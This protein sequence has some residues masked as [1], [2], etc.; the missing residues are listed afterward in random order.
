MIT[1]A[2]VMI[3]SLSSWFDPRR[4]LAARLAW[5]VIVP[6]M[7]LAPLIGYIL[8]GAALRDVVAS[9]GQLQV[10]YANQLAD[11]L[12][13]NIASHQ[14]HVCLLAAAISAQDLSVASARDLVN[15]A[16]VSFPEFAWIG[17]AD[18]DGIV[19]VATDGLLEGTDVSTRPWYALGRE[20]SRVHDVHD[21]VSLAKLLPPTPNGLP[22]RYMDI[23]AP[24]S[25]APG[26]VLGASLNW[27]WVSQLEQRALAPLRA[28]YRVDAL[29]VDANRRVLLGP[30]A[31]VGSQ[32]A[33]AYL[34]A[35]ATDPRYSIMRWPDGFEYLTGIATADGDGDFRGLGWT[36]LVR[37]PTSEAFAS[38]YQLREQTTLLG[39]LSGLIFSA[40]SV[41]TLRRLTSPLVQ[42]ATA[43]DRIENLQPDE[44]PLFHRQDEIGTLSRSLNTL[45]ASLERRVAE[46]TREVER[47]SR[48]NM[49]SAVTLERL[50]MSRDLHDTLAHTL[51]GLLVQ[52]RLVRK[53]ARE[54]IPE[55]AAELETAETSAREALLEARQAIVNLRENPVCDLGLPEAMRKSLEAFGQRTGIKA[56]LKTPP[57]GLP[58]LVDSRAETV[59]RIFEEALNNV[60]KHARANLV[61]VAISM[62]EGSARKAV[63]I[64]IADDGVG[65]EVGKPMEGHY[66]LRGI[67][68]QC[69]LI[70]AQSEINSKP[71]NGTS[72]KIMMPEE[73]NA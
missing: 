54:R 60:E 29:I 6:S 19:R 5:A 63:I 34:S 51:T 11:E 22:A 21:D 39:L 30:A 48:E 70:G 50:R 59:Y 68:E 9:A 24:I 69:E 42:I 7:V 61:Q 16:R 17:L 66:G 13:T 72:V 56:E 14:Q 33:P 44:I 8:G 62:A 32:L 47:L 38:A 36:V 53:L 46:R 73:T 41:V 37:K 58:A 55:V 26:A 71:G 31:L 35:S 15:R 25:R 4:S 12:D 67:R 18:S 23:S 57:S 3:E 1:D 49:D 65:F 27:T 20:Q 10:E 43:A 2:R 40:L 64:E 52:I 28:Q 45:V